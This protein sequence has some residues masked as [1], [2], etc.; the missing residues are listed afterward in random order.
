MSTAE[1]ETKS[2]NQQ[3]LIR[4]RFEIK[5]CHQSHLL[6]NKSKVRKIRYCIY[7]VELGEALDH[8]V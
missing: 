1:D 7:I 2:S 4:G 6:Q 8:L 5:Q 3:P